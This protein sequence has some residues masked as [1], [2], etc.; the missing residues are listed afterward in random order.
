MFS[1]HKSLGLPINDVEDEKTEGEHEARNHVNPLKTN[2]SFAN[3]PPEF[4]QLQVNKFSA[5][6]FQV[7]FMAES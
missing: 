3:F 6:N 7:R 1:L 5:V 4:S 2:N